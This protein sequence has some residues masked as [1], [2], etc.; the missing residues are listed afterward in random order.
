MTKPVDSVASPDAAT[1]RGVAG[2]LT[3]V[4]RFRSLNLSSGARDGIHDALRTLDR[5]AP[6][7]TDGIW[8]E[9]LTVDVAPL[10]ADWDVE[11]CHRWAAWPSPLEHFLTTTA[12]DTGIDLV[13]QRRSDDR[14][15]A[16]QCE[17]WQLDSDGTGHDSENR[18]S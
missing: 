4:R 9:D 1:E 18:W 8:L 7:A 13:A 17:A 6:L 14:L 3:L 11:A 10:L 15:I 5:F 2:D 12:V 16:I